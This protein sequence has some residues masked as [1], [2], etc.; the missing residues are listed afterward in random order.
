MKT[1]ES[2]LGYLLN[3]RELKDN[4]FLPKYYSPS[5]EKRLLALG[6]T[7]DIVLFEDLVK[8]KIVEVDT[9]DEIGKMAYGTGNIPFI[10]TSDIS[11]WEVK[12]DAKQ[13]VSLSIYEEYS[14]DQD[15][16]AGDIFLVKDGTY[17]VGQ[18]CIITE[19]YLP[20]LY[21]S[22]ILKIRV[23]ENDYISN[24]LFFAILNS[25]IVR[26]QIRSFQF[27]A[28]IIDTIGNR[29][30]RLCLPVPKVSNV[31]KKVSERIESLSKRRTILRNSM[32]AVPKKIESLAKAKITDIDPAKEFASITD[33]GFTRKNTEIK[34]ESLIPKYYDPQLDRDLLSFSKNYQLKTIG[35]L[36]A[37]DVIEWATGIEVGKMAYG[38]GDIPFV[39]TSDIT[40]SELKADPK[41][42]V[43]EE[44]YNAN[45]QDVK[46]EDIFIVRDG[47]YLVG[48]SCILT[49]FETKILFCG[50][51]YKIRVREVDKLD[52]YLLLALLNT[53]IVKRQMRSKQFTRDII[54]TL[55]K[56]I[57]EIILP[58]PK[59][60]GICSSIALEMKSI[61]QERVRLRDMGVQT[62]LYVENNAD[63][64]SFEQ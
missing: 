57:F 5:I 42:G 9:G 32:I 56:R 50:G 26:E 58:F 13:G 64:M 60:K 17:L 54:D 52:P 40:N 25:P 8:K 39:R 47:T 23:I 15:V 53:I 16:R 41:Q 61:I 2:R 45:K 29:Y 14:K 44:I 31:R 62:A 7:H 24:W 48:T 20:C 19:D 59:D 33:V 12:T 43:S 6:K 63:G 21:Q 1:N 37:E 30:L 49:E 46:S 34:W 10:R 22:H 51:L 28:D 36:V 27:T 38:T 11:N 4:I 35:Q 55:G 18:S 3:I